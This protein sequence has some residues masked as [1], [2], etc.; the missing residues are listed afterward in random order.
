M[1]KRSTRAPSAGAAKRSS[2]AKDF[3][4]PTWLRNSKA[5]GR[6]G[7]KPVRDGTTTPGAYKGGANGVHVFRLIDLKTR[8]TG[9]SA[10]SGRRKAG[11]IIAANTE[12][13]LIEGSKFGVGL[14]HEK[15]GMGSRPHHH[16]N[17]QMIFVLKGTVRLRIANQPE[18][19]VPTGSV[20]YIP[21]NTVHSSGASAD[22]DV[23][24]YIVKDLA[25]QFTAIPVDKSVSGPQTDFA[26]VKRRT[27]RKTARG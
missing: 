12:A 11:D 16:P 27:Q 24:S 1:T 18:M 9:A 19:I 26:A 5:G 8:Q 13:V 4:L 6:R 20:A 3:P 22:G 15:A 7:R 10:K 21:A 14:Y 2:T 23:I 25:Y 17:D